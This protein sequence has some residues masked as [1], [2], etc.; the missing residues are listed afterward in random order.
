[1]V[2]QL[3]CYLPYHLTEIRAVEKC[4]HPKHHL[5]MI[6]ITEVNQVH[7]TQEAKQVS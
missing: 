4:L 3:L 1:M 2:H 5:Q 7:M 6:N